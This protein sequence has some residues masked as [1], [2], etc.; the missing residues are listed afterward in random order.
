MTHLNPVI[1]GLLGWMIVLGG[2]LG[3]PPAVTAQSDA[4]RAMLAAFIDSVDAVQ[5]FSAVDSIATKWKDKQ[6]SGMNE[7]RRGILDW[8]KGHL[9]GDQ[10]HYVDAGKQFDRAT[11]RASDWP[12]P[13][14]LL[15]T[16]K[17]EMLAEAY[18]VYGVTQQQGAAYRRYYQEGLRALDRSLEV[19]PAFSPATEFMSTNQA[20]LAWLRTED[21]ANALHESR[22]DDV[23]L[24]LAEGPPPPKWVPPAATAF[25]LAALSP[26]RLALDSFR[27]SL[28]RLTSPNGV[29]A[30]ANRW[31]PAVH[32]FDPE[33]GALR[34]AFIEFRVAELTEDSLGYHQALESIGRANAL[35]PTEPYVWYGAGVSR[36]GLRSLAM[37]DP[38]TV[39][40]KA[41][42]KAHYE[43]AMAALKRSLDLDPGFVP[44]LEV[45]LTMAVQEDNRVQPAWILEAIARVNELYAKADPRV[46][47]VQGRHLRNSGDAMAGLTAFEQFVRAG[48]EIG[49][50]A[51]ELARTLADL[52][53]FEGA[54]QAYLSGLDHFS[55]AARAVY[56]RDISWV[57]EYHELAEFDAQQTEALP[58]WIRWFWSR[59]DATSVRSDG[60]RLR[61]HLRRWSYVNGAFRVTAPQARAPLNPPLMMVFQACTQDID[62]MTLDDLGVDTPT[63]PDDLRG[64]E[65]IYD[66]RAAVHMRHGFPARRVWQI[67]G[68]ADSV[69]TSD[70]RGASLNPQEFGERDPRLNRRTSPFGFRDAAG[71]FGGG[72]RE[73]WLYYFAGAPRMVNFQD[74]R[75]LGPGP[76]TMVAVIPLTMDYLD[77]LSAFGT[78]MGRDFARIAH[79]A[80]A[81]D[82]GLPRA[83]ISTRCSMPGQRVQQQ[84][85]E[86]FK[87]AAETDSYTLLFPDN[88]FPSV[89]VF[90]MP[91]ASGARTG[92]M[93]VAFAA[94]TDNLAL[95]TPP[96]DGPLTLPLRLRIS[97]VDPQARHTVFRDTILR[98]E[99]DPSMELPDQLSGIV[100][101]SVPAGRYNVR[102]AVQQADSAVGNVFVVG[103]PVEVWIHG[104]G[105]QL[106]DLV[107][108]GGTHDAL[109]RFGSESV[110]VNPLVAFDRSATV[111]V[112]Y[113]QSGLRPETVYHTTITLQGAEADDP[114]LSISFDE[115][116]SRRIETKRRGLTL[117]NIDSGTYQLTLSIREQ[118]SQV[119]VRRTRL[120]QVAD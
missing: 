91:P 49:I 92:T 90:G 4:G 46:Y 3:T 66:H 51:L 13:W 67:V 114:L 74:S 15:A 79:G 5:T 112:F 14:Y 44:T 93:L 48:G 45:V 108:G 61:E 36:L 29:R 20:W 19:D 54:R 111:E 57:A 18:P 10:R 55:P 33:W 99:V 38:E 87:I 2:G 39:E 71:V 52:G 104:S 53:E 24:V 58:E 9:S 64:W 77:A 65:P 73:T 21:V 50:A 72:S 101:L 82:A 56:R 81:R 28:M 95:P 42:Y 63:R 40:P 23:P 68:T 96:T 117:G 89:Q 8:H 85:A 110:P 69:A 37:R 78:S 22:E 116:A 27:D 6:P 47:L 83:A 60:D 7:M 103:E 32:F 84:A 35:A 30:V 107:T 94:P 26:A 119:A 100:E 118:G 113:V 106:S 97:A 11:R 98:F 59:R 76:T 43:P 86:D 88:L 62:H 80:T 115:V 25:Q 16:T 102:V 120:I 34:L 31:N 41:G 75:A 1:A 17:L 70:E 105:I 109:W 12:Y